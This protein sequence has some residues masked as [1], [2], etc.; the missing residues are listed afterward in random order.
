[1]SEK[2]DAFAAFFRASWPRLYRSLYGVVGDHQLAED[3]LQVA[4]MRAC[5]RWSRV[6]GMAAPEA[7][8]RRI[9]FHEILARR[10]TAAFRRE[11]AAADTWS[12]DGGRRPASPVDL[13]ERDEMWT[14]ILALPPRQRAVI[15][16]RYYEG[17]S[18]AEIAEA[19]DCRPGTVKSQASAGLDR[20]RALL[21]AHEGDDS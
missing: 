1:M 3:A 11:S 7:Y 6:R 17:L 9:A 12:G 4:M 16:L 18:E 10:R 19:L 21:P 13:G 2:D 15:V 5:G 20:L 14:A 8:V